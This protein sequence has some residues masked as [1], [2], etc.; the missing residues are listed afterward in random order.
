MEQ[1]YSYIETK[2]S[3]IITTKDLVKNI[4]NAVG[5]KIFTVN[6]FTKNFDRRQLTGRLNVLKYCGTGKPTVDLDRYLVVFEMN[7]KQYRNVS[8]KGIAWIKFQNKKWMF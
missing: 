3:N 1:V 6:F 7:K 5:S 8:V 2:E 4:Q